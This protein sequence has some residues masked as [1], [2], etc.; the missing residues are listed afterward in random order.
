MKKSNPKAYQHFKG[1]IGFKGG[2]ALR[3]RVGKHTA[4]RGSRCAVKKTVECHSVCPIKKTH[5]ADWTLA[6]NTEKCK[7]GHKFCEGTYTTK[8]GKTHSWGAFACRQIAMME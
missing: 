5:N 1:A 2:A 8:D 3:C 4:C 6:K 7:N